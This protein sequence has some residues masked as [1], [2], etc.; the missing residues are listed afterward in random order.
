MLTFGIEIET[1]LPPSMSHMEAARKVAEISG[2][3][4]A[5]AGYTHATT[6]TW[7]LVTDGSIEPYG[8]GAEF[9]S[10]VLTADEA[11]FEN[12]R[13]VVAAINEIGCSVNRSTGFHVHVGARNMPVAF[14]REVVKMYVKFEATIDSIMPRSRRGAGNR[15]CR[16]VTVTS[17]RDFDNATTLRDI[18]RSVNHLGGEPRYNKLNVHA[19]ERHGT[20]EFRQHSGTTDPVKV[21][22]WTRMVV[23]I[24]ERAA[25]I[26]REAAPTR[27][28]TREVPYAAL[29]VRPGSKL[30]IIRDLLLRG[31]TTRAEVMRATG[32]TSVSMQQQADALGMQLRT[33]K[34]GRTM[35]YT[36]VYPN[37]EEAITVAPPS[38][39]NETDSLPANLDGLFAYAQAGEGLRNYYRE[40]Q[41]DLS[42]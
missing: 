37:R 18:L 32:W 42:A 23:G 8:R 11:G 13:K 12:A 10:P 20:I 26:A 6:P 31:D 15:W 33:R 4:C 5:Y 3:P 1:V 25:R 16:P 2:I 34:A 41:A 29:T 38:Q 7:K 17:Q 21:L 9:V 30:A 14:W 19:Y 27:T 22:N 40:R 39:P 36:G 28:V 35:F 24:C